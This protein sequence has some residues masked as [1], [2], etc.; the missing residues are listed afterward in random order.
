MNP[1]IKE[2][3]AIAFPYLLAAALPLAGLFLA[4]FRASEKKYYDAGLLT[5]CALLGA[6]IFLII[7]S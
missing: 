3:I 1:A 7:L 2:R 6:L 5:L 4:I